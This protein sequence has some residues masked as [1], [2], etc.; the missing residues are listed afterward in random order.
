MADIHPGDIIAGRY[1]VN[2][3]LGRARGLLLDA[4][5][6][7]FDQRVVIRVISPALADP[8]A[9]DQFQRETRILSQLESAHVARIIDV[10]TL[11]NGSLYLVRE[12]LDGS[13]LSGARLPV[14][15]VVD[16]FLQVCEAVI[17]AHSH[18]VVLRDLQLGHVFLTRKRNGEPVAKLTDFGTCKIMRSDSPGELTCTKLMGLSP[19]A[20]PELVRQ[21]KHIDHRADIWSLGCLLYELLTGGPAF[22]GQGTALML[23]IAQDSPV[24]PS[25]LRRDGGVGGDL[26]QIVLRALS[27][28]PEAR[29]AS[30]YDLV[31]GLGRYASRRGQLVIEQIAAIA[32]EPVAPPAMGAIDD[33]DSDHTMAMV[34]SITPSDPAPALTQPPP[35]MLPVL[36]AP[37]F[38]SAPPAGGRY[39]T[40]SYLAHGG[41]AAAL[42]AAAG[43]QLPTERPSY[44]WEQQLESS[45]RSRRLK[46]AG[47]LALA[48][49]AALLLLIVLSSGDV[50][51][52]QAGMA[53]PD[54]ELVADHVA[55][56]VDGPAETDH[57]E[58]AEDAEA[59]D[60]ADADVDD[61]TEVRSR[62]PAP[63]QSAQFLGSLDDSTSSKSGKAG[64]SRKAAKSGKAGKS[65]KAA[66]SGKAGKSRKAASDGKAGAVKQTG[67][68]VAMAL[69]A[70]CVFA[71]DGASRGASSSI[72]LQAPV[73]SH[74]VTCKPTKGGAARSRS[75]TVKP[76]EA[77]TTIFRF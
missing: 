26:D 10:G 17:E 31:R 73:G 76:G 1:R 63:A 27:K 70:S 72:R 37:R 28:E 11:P 42:P 14:D 51:S 62:R 40:G 49:V 54:L 58:A 71:V 9:I 67:T 30:V 18:G 77:A 15:Q 19:S 68:I 35:A 8:K 47:V 20:S 21:H 25:C 43:A 50:A 29:H 74:V 7:S 6:T 16:L 57:D 12:H 61:G 38:P 32:G 13:K 5:H 46:V 33:A 2:A 23:A 52:A 44:P 34:R 56:P 39:L 69:G 75:V 45:A 66:K 55:E 53:P 48:P 22:H 64:K 65:R 41:T 24:P 4:A 60:A 59:A 3:V 36:P